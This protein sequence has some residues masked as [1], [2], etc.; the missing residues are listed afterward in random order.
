MKKIF[1]LS[2]LVFSVFGC[3]LDNDA[4]NFYNEALPIESVNVPETFQFGQVYQ[5]DVTYFRPTG[6]HI[7]N[8]FLVENDDNETTIVLLNTVYLNSDC[9]TFEAN[10]N[11]TEASFNF[12][13]NNIGTHVF[14]FWQGKDDNGSDVYLIV[15]VPVE[16]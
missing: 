7:F 15:E 3:S 1:L 13:V 8:N 12:Q 14:K 11:Q 2:F 9:Q 16:E 4:I 5:I 6:C 10:S